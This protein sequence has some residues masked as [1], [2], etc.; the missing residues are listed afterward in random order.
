MAL[1]TL[2]VGARGRMAT[3]GVVV[4]PI[5]AATLGAYADY[6]HRLA[7]GLDWRLQLHDWCAVPAYHTQAVAALPALLLW[8]PD[9]EP[10]RR[11]FPASPPGPPPLTG[12]EARLFRP[13]R[14]ELL[15]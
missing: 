14:V 11:D 5:A 9:G 1:L 13:K 8:L 2:L 4:F 3:L 12:L 7:E 6:G 15:L 10:R